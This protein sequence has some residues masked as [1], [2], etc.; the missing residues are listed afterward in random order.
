MPVRAPCPTTPGAAGHVRL[1]RTA[2]DQK[3]EHRLRVRAQTA[4]HAAHGH[5]SACIARKTGLHVDTVRRRR[6]RFDQAGLPG[7]KD[8]QRCGSRGPSSR[9]RQRPR[10][11]PRG[12]LGVVERCSTTNADNRRQLGRGSQR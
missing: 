7:L 2:H 11:D 6:G 12:R 1:K 4:L 10:G 5:S 9:K 3:T 8:R